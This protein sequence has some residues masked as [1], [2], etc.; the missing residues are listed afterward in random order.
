[1]S[2]PFTHIRHLYIDGQWFEPSAGLEAIINPATEETIGHAPV[3]G[4]DAVEAAL[5][6]ARRAF[7]QGPW[8][9]T[10]IEQRIEAIQRLRAVILKKARVQQISWRRE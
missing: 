4:R 6:A 2:V 3:G 7:D 5:S 8:A 10:S 1:M 9:Q